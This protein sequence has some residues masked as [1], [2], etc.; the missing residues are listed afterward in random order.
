MN[1][2]L[3]AGIFYPRKR[4][5]RSKSAAGWH[6]EKNAKTCYGRIGPFPKEAVV[7]DTDATSRRRRR[8]FLTLLVFLA[9][10]FAGTA[11]GIGSVVF[12]PVLG[13]DVIDAPTG[14]A[15]PDA[16]VLTRASDGRFTVLRYL[17]EDVKGPARQVAE[18]TVIVRSDGAYA[19]GFVIRRGVIVTAAHVAGGRESPNVNV[20]CADI[21]GPADVVR[22]DALRDVM[23]LH[24]AHCDGAILRLDARPLRDGEPLHV[25]GFTFNFDVNGALRFHRLTTALPNKVFD[26]TDPATKAHMERM[27][28]QGVPRLQAIDGTL[29]RGNSGSPVFTENGGIVGMFVIIDFG[30]RVSYMVP[31]SSVVRVLLDAD[32]K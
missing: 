5:F 12:Y 3:S 14:S 20:N 26:P 9:A 30:P 27:R 7:N 15:D 22:I 31:T 17:P 19:T 6:L 8:F 2:R 11:V 13:P 24:A 28:E 25:S 18:Q 21:D 4:H 1:A 32:V 16:P 29:V 23:I 10:L